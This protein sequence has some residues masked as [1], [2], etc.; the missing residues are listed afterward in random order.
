MSEEM[1]TAVKYIHPDALLAYSDDGWSTSTIYL[2]HT[3]RHPNW[4]Q[5]SLPSKQQDSGSVQ[6]TTFVPSRQ[7]PSPPTPPRKQ[8]TPPARPSKHHHTVEHHSQNATQ[9]ATPR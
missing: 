1:E 5:K 8:P 3:R 7:A 6:C 9:T 4:R 2:E